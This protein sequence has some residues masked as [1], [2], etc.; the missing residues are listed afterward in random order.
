MVTLTGD[1]CLAL[2]QIYPVLTLALVIEL[3]ILVTVGWLWPV[4][5]LWVALALGTSGTVGAVLAGQDGASGMNGA[6]MIVELAA[7]AMALMT[8]TSA[9]TL[10]QYLAAR[11]DECDLSDRHSRRNEARDSH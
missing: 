11:G 3:R 2:A 4:V 9:V 1:Q 6:F 10:G 5:T 8:A 7:I